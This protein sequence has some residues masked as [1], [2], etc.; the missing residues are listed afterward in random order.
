MAKIKTIGDKKEIL[1]R[2]NEKVD[3]EK[4]ITSISDMTD[5]QLTDWFEKHFSGLP[6]E[7]RPGMEELVR[8]VWANAKL[9][10][11]LHMKG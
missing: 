6:D 5:T 1:K 10:K 2:R 11:K 3:W 4:S 7:T 8:A 9:T